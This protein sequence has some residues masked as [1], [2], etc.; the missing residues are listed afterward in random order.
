MAKRKS[1]TRTIA[2][3]GAKTK[4]KARAKA[5]KKPTPG[6]S[7]RE[8]TIAGG[9]SFFLRMESGVWGLGI[10]VLGSLMLLA[11]LSF[12]LRRSG[13]SLEE[14]RNL[15]GPVG[16]HLALHVYFMLGMAGVLLAMATVLFGALL[17][18]QKF[19]VLR[20]EH[21]LG[22][23]VIVLPVA[24][25]LHFITPESTALPQG[26][27]GF[28][29]KALGEWVLARL[30]G[31]AGTWVLAIAAIVAGLS[32]IFR[33]HVKSFFLVPWVLSHRLWRALTQREQ[34]ESSDSTEFTSEGSLTGMEGDDSASAPR[35]VRQDGPG[36]ATNVQRPAARSDAATAVKKPAEAVTPPADE[37]TRGDRPATAEGAAA[38]PAVK[39][40]NPDLMSEDEFEAAAAGAEA[41]DSSNDGQIPPESGRVVRKTKPYVMPDISLLDYNAPSG[42]KVDDDQLHDSAR[43]LEEKLEDFKIDGS[44]GDIHP[45]PVIA[46]YEFKPGRGVK[47][48]TISN[49]SKDIAMALA[50]EQVRIVAPIPGRDVV[51]FE[52]PN[53]VREMVHLRELLQHGSY[54]SGKQRMPMVL[55]KDIAG[56]P[57]IT[58]LTKMPHL[59]VA[60]TTGSGKSVAVHSYI[61]SILFR[62]TPKD[63]RF[64]FIDPKMLELTAYADI[65]HLLLPVVT[66][67]RDAAVALRWAVGEMERRNRIMS[68][69]SVPNITEFNQFVR[70][71]KDSPEGK[72]ALKQITKS[73][74]GVK[75]EQI[76][77]HEN[78]E[79]EELPY[80]AIVIDEL[81]DLMM[82]AGKQVESSIAR[83]AQ[84]ARAAGIHMIIATQNPTIKVVTGIIKANMPSRISFKV[85]T[86]QDSRVILDQN[87]ADDLLGYGDMLFLGPGSSKLKRIHGA[88]VTTEERNRVVDYL[89]GQGQ[90]A[91]NRDIMATL[92]AGDDEGAENGGSSG[93][94]KDELY[95]QAVTIAVARGKISTSAL[96]RELG[97]GYNKAAVLMSRM[98]REGVVGPP[99]AAGKPRTVLRSR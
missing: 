50:A 21:L 37:Q 80:I 25:I 6:A 33:I 85:R 58:D 40:Q 23:S 47:L 63:V 52:I 41:I 45:G 94:P 12:V 48:S 4:V 74:T 56:N 11:L 81:S 70:K 90:P 79:L 17:I 8:K 91:Y 27:G 26:W 64:I 51:G 10:S 29:G 53:K 34:T 18:A 38:D 31:T 77:A 67:A 2:N 96:Q 36:D 28:V 65:P 92:E 72:A 60:G 16:A 35:V 49:L 82:V 20:R 59:L 46:L 69:A 95:D 5:P 87:G 7:R 1:G 98:E 15:I 97:I 99:E 14:G 66:E 19:A 32:I 55:G 22:I 43:K 73:F 68:A 88:F 61:L 89:R 93:D 42:R 62:Y 9:R 44:V 13:G 76:F 39:R 3:T 24:I 84:M 71:R 83:L 54:Q 30:L 75:R 86:M 78:E 57:A